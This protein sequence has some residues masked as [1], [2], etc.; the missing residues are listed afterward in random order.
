MALR[1]GK[2]L[3]SLKLQDV[4]VEIS[5]AFE[6]R[7]AIGDGL[8]EFVS[9]GERRIGDGLVLEA[10]CVAEAFTVGGFDVTVVSAIMF[11][12]GIEVP[13]VNKVKCLGS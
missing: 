5:N 8:H 12:G 1:V 13:T 10:D 6:C 11:R 2:V 9:W 3:K 4:L 7:G